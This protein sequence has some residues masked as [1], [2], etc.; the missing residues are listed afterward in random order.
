[1]Q[2]EST[3]ALTDDQ[4]KATA[5]TI[6]DQQTPDGMILWFPN[7][8][9]DTWN[10]TEAAMALSAAGFVDAAER[11]Y[12]WLAKNQR[13]DGSWHHYY[14]ENAIEDA[15]VDTNCCAYVAT[16]VWHHYL[17]TRDDHFLE[18]LWPVVKR[19]LDFVVGHQTASGHIPWAIHTSGTAWSYSLVTGSSSIYHS[20]RCGLAIALHIDMEQPEWEF[21]AVRLSSLLRNNEEQFEPKKRWAMD[22]Y[23]PVLTQALTGI[24]A[25]QRLASR[26]EEFM[27]DDHGVRCVSD[28][29]W[30]TTA[31][32]CECAMAYLAI[33]DE[34][35]A[36]RL[37]QSIQPLRDLDGAYFTGMVFPETITF[38]DGERSTYSSAAVI[39]A[40]DALTNNSAASQLVLGHGL[41]SL[42]S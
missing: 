26:V 38:P 22:W 8:H 36:H 28:Q 41:P 1:M 13:A 35:T 27:L 10:H 23:Y 37:F 3:G 11:A 15:K 5:S 19:A 12:Q 6:I 39:L 16:G 42:G 20:L 31:E 34:A 25:S 18:E 14:L 17:N 9:S 2:P 4:I 24:P 21:A 32:T 29:P 30:V 33:G 7:G 40:S